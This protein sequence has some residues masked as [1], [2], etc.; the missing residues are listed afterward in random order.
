MSTR[1]LGPVPGR[2]GVVY[3]STDEAQHPQASGHRAADALAYDPRSPLMA[4]ALVL[5]L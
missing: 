4:E 2:P 3:H 5:A 1:A